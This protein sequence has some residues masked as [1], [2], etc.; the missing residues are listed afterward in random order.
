M[1]IEGRQR[2]S[3]ASHAVSEEE[4]NRQSPQTDGEDR[5]A[6]SARGGGR[7]E[8][9]QQEETIHPLKNEKSREREYDAS[10][11]RHLSI[12]WNQWEM[13]PTKEKIWRATSYEC[14]R[15]G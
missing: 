3:D 1:P 7:K 2:I 10:G 11:E 13:E 9:D 5:C 14:G 4:V 12:G 8:C 6:Q 15:R